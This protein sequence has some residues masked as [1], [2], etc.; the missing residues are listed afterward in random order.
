MSTLTFGKKKKIQNSEMNSDDSDHES[1]SNPID[2][3][4]ETF[5]TEISRIDSMK[6]KNFESMEKILT[7]YPLGL[8]DNS[9]WKNYTENR[10]TIYNEYQFRSASSK[11]LL[12]DYPFDGFGSHFPMNKLQAVE[13]YSIG[14]VIKHLN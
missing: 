3:F 11:R 7:K 9:K 14:L 1:S 6:V 8:V 13:N 12:F 5:S 10:N 2:D 4:F